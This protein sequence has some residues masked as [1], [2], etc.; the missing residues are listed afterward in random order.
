MVVRE[1][2]LT[3]VLSALVEKDADVSE[4]VTAMAEGHENAIRVA[5]ALVYGTRT[6]EPA[7]FAQV[8]P[9]VAHRGKVD[10]P[11]LGTDGT[12]LVVQL[13][14]DNALLK[15]LAQASKEAIE[16]SINDFLASRLGGSG[17]LKLR[18]SDTEILQVGLSDTEILQIQLCE[19]EI[20][21]V[22]LSDQNTVQVQLSDTEI[23]QI[24]VIDSDLSQGR[25]RKVVQLK[26]GDREILQVRL[27][28]TEILQLN[29]SDTEILQLRLS[30]TE[31]LQLR[32]SDTEILQVRLSDT[33][34]LQSRL[35][36]TE[37]L[38]AKLSEIGV[39]Q[40]PSEYQD[41]QARLSDT[42]I[43]QLRRSERFV[44]AALAV[45]EECGFPP[46]VHDTADL[47]LKIAQIFS[48][49]VGPDRNEDLLELLLAV[50]EFLP[51]LEHV[52]GSTEA[53]A[54]EQLAKRRK[55]TL[56]ALARLAS[57][58]ARLLKALVD[59]FTGGLGLVPRVDPYDEGVQPAN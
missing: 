37:I 49:F 48:M 11:G 7:D 56:L 2:S 45:L 44:S 14:G 5:S 32:L 25:Q 13:A 6:V 35:S 10:R 12:Q 21:K 15:K 26:L 18:L 29:L 28:D 20:L 17:V 24:Q 38:Q 51:A 47:E 27:S 59:V 33:E 39:A 22:R 8:A 58:K 9:I 19:D 46:M 57:E 54:M 43:L 55:E 42:E 23:L 50:A 53:G 4:V 3:R 1:T 36:D 34:I 16:Q 52:G 40:K 31:I 30:D 41:G